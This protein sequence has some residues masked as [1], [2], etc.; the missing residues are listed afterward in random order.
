MTEIICAAI[1][2][3]ASIVCAF[4]AAA[5]KRREKNEDKRAEAEKSR[6]AKILA[7]CDAQKIVMLDRIRYLGQKYIEAGEIDF[8]DRR[9]LNA[10]HSSYHTGLGGNGDADV[11]MHEVNKLPLKRAN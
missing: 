2:A 10:M 6:D 11:V 1:T 8:D 4:A 9:I 3:T 5:L 7:L